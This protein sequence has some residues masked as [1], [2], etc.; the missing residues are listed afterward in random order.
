MRAQRLGNGGRG[1]LLRTARE[2]GVGNAARRAAGLDGFRRGA[3]VKYRYTIVNEGVVEAP[4]M[5]EAEAA[6]FESCDQGLGTFA[7]E[8]EPLNKE[9]DE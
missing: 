4:N 8:L 6:A 1:V 5:A 7:V 3:A 2:A 9:R